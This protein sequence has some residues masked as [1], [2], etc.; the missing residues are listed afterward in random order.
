MP[1]LAEYPKL[2]SHRAMATCCWP[3]NALCAK[4]GRCDHASPSVPGQRYT[5]CWGLMRQA[6]FRAG[7]L[8][9]EL[10]V[11]KLLEPSPSQP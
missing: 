8:L 7:D 1:S 6:C 2:C 11:Q 4:S 10:R 9:N 5:W 3:V